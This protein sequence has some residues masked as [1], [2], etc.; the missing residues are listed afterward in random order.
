MPNLSLIV[1][2]AS[3]SGQSFAASPHSLYEHF[4]Y[5][6]IVERTVL[7]VQSVDS[8]L[9]IRQAQAEDIPVRQHF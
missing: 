3:T 7:S 9:L 8:P 6:M 4:E 1:E 2:Y 5:K